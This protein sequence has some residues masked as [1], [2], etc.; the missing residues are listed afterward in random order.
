MAA[1]ARLAT[2]FRVK[3]SLSA[4][5]AEERRESRGEAVAEETARGCSEVMNP[6]E[7]IVF[8][9]GLWVVEILEVILRDVIE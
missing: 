5:S 4:D 9:W 3:T 1:A 2:S 6:A 8:V 7:A